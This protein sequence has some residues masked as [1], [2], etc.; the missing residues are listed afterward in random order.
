MKPQLRVAAIVIVTGLFLTGCENGN[1]ASNNDTAQ[2]KPAPVVQN[3]SKEQDGVVEL[4]WDD[5]MPADWSVNDLIDEY[6]TSDISDDD[7]RALELLKQIQDAMKDAPVTDAYEGK[8][9]KIPGFVVPLELDA[10]NIRE[11][12][13]VPYFGACIHVPPP[14]A[15]QTVHVVADEDRAYQGELFDTVWVTGTMKLERMS[16]NLGSS[17]YRIEVTRVEPFE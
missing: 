9:V 8:E 12:L 16:N 17:G 15:N 6:N 1:T 5:L 14:P 2:E 10:T 13:L 4:A 11:F 7:P 3:T